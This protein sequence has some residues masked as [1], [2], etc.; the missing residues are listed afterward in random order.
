MGLGAGRRRLC[1]KK[2][3]AVAGGPRES[4]GRRAL[5]AR[6]WRS[7]VA[8][9]QTRTGLTLRERGEK[10]VDM[11]YTAVGMTVKRFEQRLPNDKPLRQLTEAVLKQM[12]YV[13]GV[14][15]KDGT[16]SKKLLKG[17]LLCDREPKAHQIEP[18]LKA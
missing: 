10:V 18:S 12:L 15:P 9:G 5:R 13:D 2:G 6:N 14:L 11:D 17:A 8:Y 3:G 16:P 4:T 1:A 7:G